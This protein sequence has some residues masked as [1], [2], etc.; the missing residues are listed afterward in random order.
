MVSVGEL[1]RSH[2]TLSVQL[3]GIALAKQSVPDL[4]E[5]WHVIKKV[6]AD[7]ERR[8]PNEVGRDSFAVDLLDMGSP[9]LS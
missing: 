2:P 8:L 1:I 6:S 9:S 3:E 5:G 4:L 7:R